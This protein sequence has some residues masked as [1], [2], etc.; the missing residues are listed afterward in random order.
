MIRSVT[1]VTVAIALLVACRV[2]PAG[3]ALP[4]KCASE[5]EECVAKATTGLLSCHAKAE[6]KGALEQS[7]LT[8]AATKFD[9]GEIPEQGC[10]AG[11]EARYSCYTTNDAE[12]MQDRLEAFVLDVVH[13]LDPGYP[14]PI[15]NRCSAGKKK[16]VLDKIAKLSSCYSKAS[17][18]GFAVDTRCVAKAKARFDGGEA[19][20]RGCFA[21]LESKYGAA[22]LT[23]G[24]SA[25]LGALVDAFV[26]DVAANL[27]PLCGNNVVESPFEICDGTE[28][29]ACPGLCAPPGSA[30]ECTC[31]F[32]GD[33]QVNRPGEICD[34]S[35]DDACPEHC[36][37]DCTC[38]TCGNDVAEPFVEDCDGSD[39]ETCPGRCAAP[40]ASNE[41]LCPVCGDGIVNQ[42]SEEC[43]GSD[44]TACPGSC[45]P[46]CACAVCGNG[47]IESPVETCDGSNAPACPDQCGSPGASN[48]CQ[49]PTCGDNIVNRPVEQ[50]DGSDDVACS[51]LCS[52]SC[53]CPVCG[54]GVVNQTS[55]ECD[56]GD[57]AACSGLCSDSCRCPFCGDNLVNQASEECDGSDTGECSFLCMPNCLCL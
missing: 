8:R 54:D 6:A 41:C 50:C 34:R 52:A 27:E 20:E 16:C 36:A 44:A 2:S 22:C 43:D 47:V 38:A 37:N 53:E 19:P 46:T 35:D 15:V 25:T 29:S 31:P 26:D 56:G 42:A 12:P 28:D 40:G 55:E 17:R 23:S 13:R 24:D 30:F 57:D 33:H 1:G 11:L 4:N 49:C 7:C 9:G 21:K 18:K 32:C 10:F 39:D 14:D 48:A 51:G 45:L 3:A 5:K